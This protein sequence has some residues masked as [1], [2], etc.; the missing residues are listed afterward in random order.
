MAPKMG[1]PPKPKDEVRSLGIHIRVTP[2]EKDDIVAYCNETGVTCRE[3]L[4]LGIAMHKR[5]KIEADK[6]K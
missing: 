1:R 4:H 5:K 3:F 6:Q 2:T